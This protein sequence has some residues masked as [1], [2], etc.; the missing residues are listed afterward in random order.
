VVARHLNAFTADH[1]HVMTSRPLDDADLHGPAGLPDPARGGSL[2][3]HCVETDAIAELVGRI[4]SLDLVIVLAATDTEAHT[5]LWK[6]LFFAIRRGGAFAVRRATMPETG[7]GR[8]LLAQLVATVEMWSD[9]EPDGVDP[10]DRELAAATDRV[11]MDRDV[12]IVSK[13]TGHFLKIREDEANEVLAARGGPVSLRVLATLPAGELRSSSTV[14][15]HT[16]TRP[17]AN[18]ETRLSYPPLHLREYTGQVGLV[19]QSLLISRDVVLPESFRHH[20]YYANLHNPQFR[21]VSQQ[22]ASIDPRLMPDE[23][24]AGSYYLVDNPFTGHFGHLMTEVVGKLWGWEQAK[25]QFP[26][27]KAIYR[28]RSQVDR[29]RRLEHRLLNAFG[30]P[31]D[32]IVATDHPVWVERMVAATPMWHNHV[33][34]YVHPDLPAVWDRLSAGV[35]PRSPGLG[36][37]IFVSRAPDTA[38]RPCRNS[39]QVEDFF[40]AHGFSILYPEKFD[41][42]EQAG[43]FADA[44]AIA[45]FGGSAMFSLLHSKRVRT[46]IVVNH[47]AYTARNEHL[48]TMLKNC[49]VHYFWSE[50]DITSAPGTW[51]N[52]AFRSPWEFDFER[53]RS[54]LEDVLRGLD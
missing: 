53:N 6:Q 26:D 44:S 40:A 37:R 42:S 28:L 23:T 16:S 39:E 25:A 29:D 48:F 13:R 54:E 4:G 3:T 46:V 31:D 35:G 21:S 9:A 32:D 30:I 43:A 52:E 38:N 17:I 27:L 45:G 11:V 5:R 22:V 10:V 51:A 14:T 36:E 18:L 47:E 24:L 15:S 19:A 49:D 41:L 20:A 34:H 12:V 50:P 2:T 33:P 7:E 8:G 1:V